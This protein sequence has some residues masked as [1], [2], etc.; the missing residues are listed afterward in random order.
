LANGAGQPACG[1]AV[2]EGS[3]GPLGGCYWTALVSVKRRGRVSV[4]NFRGVGSESVGLG[5]ED[6]EM[7]VSLGEKKTRSLL[8][9]P[10]G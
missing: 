6:V 2:M 10:R 4:S 5:R 7:V 3:E 1:S 9:R 8:S